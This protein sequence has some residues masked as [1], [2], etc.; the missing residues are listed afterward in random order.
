VTRGDVAHVG[1]SLDHDARLAGLE[2]KRGDLGVVE[3]RDSIIAD[4]IQEASP[5]W[6][7]MRTKMAAIASG[8]VR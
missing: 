4:G 1:P 7:V 2:G 5:V 6:K 3:A 8:G